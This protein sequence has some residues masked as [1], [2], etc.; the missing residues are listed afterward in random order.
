MTEIIAVFLGMAIT[1]ALLTV[2][3]AARLRRKP[4]RQTPWVACPAL[5]DK[6]SEGVMLVDANG[7]IRQPN[8]A[9]AHLF[10]LSP[11]ELDGTHLA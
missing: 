6:L 11:A 8:K 4:S 10:G 5:L 3:W 7:I 2:L 1:L 9:A